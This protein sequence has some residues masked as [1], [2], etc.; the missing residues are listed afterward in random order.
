METK[1]SHGKM[2]EPKMRT[3]HQELSKLGFSDEHF[4][5][6]FHKYLTTPAEL[7]MLLQEIEDINQFT[8]IIRQKIDNFLANAKVIIAEGER[9]AV[10][11]SQLQAH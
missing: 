4:S 7:R 10:N 5:I 11:A 2:L 3:A 1:K 9:Q 8:T 6:I